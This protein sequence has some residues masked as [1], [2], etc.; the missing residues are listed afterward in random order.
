MLSSGDGHDDLEAITVVQGASSVF[1]AR[2]DVVVEGDCN[3]V[4]SQSKRL[5]QGVYRDARRDV[6]F[7]TVD[8]KPHR[9]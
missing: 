6:A 4:A 8:R 3:A 7:G 5:Q 2:D 1:G 9:R